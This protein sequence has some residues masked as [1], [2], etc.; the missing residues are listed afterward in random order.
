[1]IARVLIGLDGS[2]LA[3]STL[4]LAEA[5]ARAGPADLLLVRACSNGSTLEEV[6]RG[7]TS[8]LRYSPAPTDALTAEAA[9]AA[10]REATEY[11]DGVARQLRARGLQVEAIV[12]AGEPADVV[13]SQAKLRGAD[14]ILLTTHGRSGLNRLVYGS[15]AEAVLGRAEVPVLLTRGVETAIP[16]TPDEP[17]RLIV[18][19]DGSSISEGALPLASRLAQGWAAEL[20]LVRVLAVAPLLPP[21]EPAGAAPT[22]VEVVP[23]DDERNAQLYLDDFAHR[24]RADGLAVTTAVRFGAAADG[25]LAAAREHAGSL[26]VMAT[27]GR[28]GLARALLGSVAL[29]VLRGGDVPV[30]LIRPDLVI[31]ASA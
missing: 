28:G 9:R 1:M 15:V 2:T 16:A 29:D 24:L 7:D 26:I 12:S 30:L 11:L 10:V 20:V 13:V 8:Y 21:R 4:P 6:A 5:L 18:P 14:L 17:L 23:D 25:I 3:E 19:L 31:P 27:H 22:P